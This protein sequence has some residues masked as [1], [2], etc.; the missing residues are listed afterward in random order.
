MDRWPVQAEALAG[1]RQLV[2]RSSSPEPLASWAAKESLPLSRGEIAGVKSA[3][4]AC[5]LGANVAR[6][7]QPR[8]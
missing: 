5:S 8:K 7:V 2:P 1:N 6:S 4:V 3:N